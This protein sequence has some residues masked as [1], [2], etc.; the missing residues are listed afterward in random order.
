[1]NLRERRKLNRNYKRAQ[2]IIAEIE[3]THDI[4]IIHQKSYTYK[5]CKNQRTA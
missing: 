5:N 3:S 4:D 2:S 1:M